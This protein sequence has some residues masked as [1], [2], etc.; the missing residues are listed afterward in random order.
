MCGTLES[1]S[2][3]PLLNHRIIGIANGLDIRVKA[4]LSRLLE[5]LGDPEV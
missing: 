2:E 1:L 3:G 4:L 5:P